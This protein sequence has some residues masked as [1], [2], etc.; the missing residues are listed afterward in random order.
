M[1]HNTSS[2]WGRSITWT[3]EAMLQSWHDFL[4]LVILERS[5]SGE[6]WPSHGQ[7][8]ETKI[9]QISIDERQWFTQRNLM[10]SDDWLRHPLVAFL[11]ERS[12]FHVS[13]QN[14]RWDVS[15]MTI[16]VGKE[17]TQS[18]LATSFTVIEVGFDWREKMRVQLCHLSFR[19]EWIK[20]SWLF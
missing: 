10:S 7:Y 14:N 11:F 9:I 18:L 6:R 15:W 16:L 1:Y 5:E 19:F 2:C 4:Y 20:Q 17:K 13:F 12:F 3:K 8:L